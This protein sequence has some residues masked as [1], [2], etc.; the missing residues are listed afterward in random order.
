MDLRP[1]LTAVTSRSGAPCPSE[2]GALCGGGCP[3]AI[4][5]PGES[6]VDGRR[7][8]GSYRPRREDRRHRSR[9]RERFRR[10]LGAAEWPGRCVK[11]AGVDRRVVGTGL[12]ATRCEEDP[13]REY[14]ARDSRGDRQVK[15]WRKHA[16]PRQFGKLFWVENDT[17]T[18]ASHSTVWPVFTAR[19][20][21]R[22]S[23]DWTRATR[24]FGSRQLERASW[25]GGSIWDKSA[26]AGHRYGR[27]TPWP[28]SANAKHDDSCCAGCA[29]N[30]KLGLDLAAD[31][32]VRAP[33]A[34]SATSRLLAS[35]SGF[36]G[37]RAISEVNSAAAP[38]S[39][40]YAA[41]GAP[42]WRTPA[43]PR[44]P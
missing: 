14:S 32:L 33:E 28:L 35:Y 39:V 17:R 22:G 3:Q 23:V 8:R 27:R 21:G 30:R 5:H 19:V 36:R 7:R 40:E 44:P 2:S 31:V 16:K 20:D 26:P 37:R 6:R 12:Q 24:H 18:K 34:V 25:S 42:V 38:R 1:Y 13:R 15:R 4:R 29:P 9:N 11:D 41:P 43:R 10:S